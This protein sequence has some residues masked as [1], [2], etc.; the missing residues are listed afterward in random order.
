MAI[1]VQHGP[2]M[3]DYGQA[4]AMAAT[5]GAANDRASAYANYLAGIQKQNQEYNLGLGNLNL[6]KT[7]ATTEATDVNNRFALNR[8]ELDQADFRNKLA[9]DQLALQA[10]VA[11]QQNTVNMIGSDAN[12]LNA[13]ANVGRTQMLGA[14]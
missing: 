5:Q 1:R 13:V 14:G 12:Y 2:S 6:A 9:Q 4:V 7:K 11:N 3:I 10:R 8:R